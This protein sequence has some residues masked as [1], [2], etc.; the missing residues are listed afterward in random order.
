MADVR[1]ETQG[2]SSRR[3]SRG[4]PLWSK[5]SIALGVMLALAA[6]FLTR[7]LF[8][9]GDWSDGALA[10]ALAAGL[11]AA[12]VLLVA[13]LR[14]LVGRRARWTLIQT[15]L[16]I[17]VLLVVAV[18]SGIVAPSL[19]ATQA[20]IAR[21]Q[22]HWQEAIEEF[23]L[24]GEHAPDAPHIAATYV[25]WGE[26]LLAQKNYTTAAVKFATVITRYAATG[27]AVIAQA[28]RDLYHT[29][30]EWIRVTPGAVLYGGDGGALASF[31][32][33]LSDPACD[34]TCQ[35][36][37]TATLALAHFQFGQQLL[38]GQDYAGAILAFETVTGQY[39]T[40]AYASQ[41]RAAAAQAYFARGRQQMAGPTCGDAVATYQTLVAHYADTPE[42]AQAKTA[43]AAPQPVSGTLTGMPTN[44]T[45]TVALSLH[46][47]TSGYAFSDDY[48]V[49]PDASGT[50]TAPHVAQGAYNLSTK[51]AVNNTISYTYY[52]D[53]QG[54][55]YTVHVGPL[56]PVRLGAIAFQ[57]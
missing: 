57:A 33:H 2:G 42:A 13:G 43:L 53:A 17:I 1:P 27:G 11:L 18:G 31:Q 22:G 9:Q 46:V 49:T 40:S 23:A 24:S 35:T 36:Q 21:S 51:R 26:Q 38:A 50:F 6:A 44:P 8:Q 29:Y 48:L 14:A 3:R 10:V 16:L 45:P 34:A 5:G 19:H 12:L 20:Q 56:C 39:A 25:A 30:N 15:G 52:H 4:L 7:T 47:N 41:A 32:Q 37:L 54:N 55:V 28:R